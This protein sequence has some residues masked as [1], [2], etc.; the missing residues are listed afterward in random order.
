MTRARDR[1]RTCAAWCWT[2]LVRR[3]IC[4]RPGRDEY[5]AGPSGHRLDGRVPMSTGRWCFAR[6]ADRGGVRARRGAPRRVV[7]VGPDVRGTQPS[8]LEHAAF[9]GLL[10]AVPGVRENGFGVACGMM[11]APA[12]SLMGLLG[13]RL[14]YSG[15]A[16]HWNEPRSPAQFS[17]M[18]AAKLLPD[19]PRSPGRGTSAVFA[20]GKG[21]R[22]RMAGPDRRERPG[23][24]RGRSQGQDAGPPPPAEQGDRA[25]VRLTSPRPPT[26]DQMPGRSLGGHHRRA[27]VTEHG[28]QRG[29]LGP[30][31][32]H[33]AGA[34]GVHVRDVARPDVSVRE[35][36]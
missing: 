17:L 12:R 18:S 30:V 34:V 6:T 27:W 33:G 5:D 20:P 11:S 15:A 23:R 25:G 19:Q 1:V 24:R 4:W 31:V 26:A 13:L 16:D 9:M 35:A 14:G 10:E 21:I 7:D 29:G 32:E 36:S 2:R 22:Q 8:S 28:P 3:R